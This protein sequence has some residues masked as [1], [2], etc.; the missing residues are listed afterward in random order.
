LGLRLKYRINRYLH[1]HPHSNVGGLIAALGLA[2]ALGLGIFLLLR[3]LS[4]TRLAKE[5]LYWLGGIVSLTAFPACWFYVVREPPWPHV[6]NRAGPLLE[7]GAAVF[8]ALLYLYQKWR[9]PAWG[10]VGM[11]AL[12]HAFW[13]WLFF[14]GPS[15]LDPRY[16]VFPFAGFCSSLAWSLYVRQQQQA[17]EA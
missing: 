11:L 4:S 1:Q 6:P 3:L 2:L 9:I 12:H 15:L 8:C 7:L 10:G 5:F 17:G 14:G 13:G 16:V